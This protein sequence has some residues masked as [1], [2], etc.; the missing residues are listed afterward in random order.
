MLPRLTQ[1]SAVDSHDGN[2]VFGSELIL[3]DSA[4][5]I[6]QPNV[7]HFRFS[8][9]SRSVEVAAFHILRTPVRPMIVTVGQSFGMLARR[10]A[11]SGSHY[12]HS[13]RVL[14]VALE[15]CVFEIIKAAV[16]L[17]R[18]LVVHIMARGAWAN[19]SGGNQDVNVNAFANVVH[20]QRDGKVSGTSRVAWLQDAIAFAFRCAAH[21]HDTAKVGHGIEALV[22]DYRFPCF[23][24]KF[25]GGKFLNRHGVTLR[26]KVAL[27]L[28]PF[29]C[30]NTCAAR[31][32]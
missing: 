9:F 29:G 28:G 5:W 19:K 26:Y 8:E 27:W 16:S 12:T 4:F 6:S 14:C 24:R 7:S 25:F 2:T 3:S 13:E 23:A 21:P 31:S 32:L 11:I 30:F 1:Q 10:V 15:S 17:N 18:I 20:R 22:S